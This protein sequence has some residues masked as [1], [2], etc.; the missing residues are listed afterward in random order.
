MII[1]FNKK[2]QTVLQISSSEVSNRLHHM[3]RTND[4]NCLRQAKLNKISSRAGYLSPGREG[5]RQSEICGFDSKMFWIYGFHF[6]GWETGLV[7][8]K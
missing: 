5:L 2:Q 6:G 7:F 3:T 8:K 1:D 4:Y